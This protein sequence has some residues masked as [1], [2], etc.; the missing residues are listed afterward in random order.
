MSLT[1][2]HSHIR[3]LNDVSYGMNAFL[4]ALHCNELL[5]QFPKLGSRSQQQPVI[6]ETFDAGSMS[7][8]KKKN[9]RNEPAN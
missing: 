6:T 7:G 2:F 8:S 4:G 3:G 5:I 1:N 9:E